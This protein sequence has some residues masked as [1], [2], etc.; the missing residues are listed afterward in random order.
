VAARLL[1]D[2]PGLSRDE[3]LNA[4]GSYHGNEPDAGIR[5]DVVLRL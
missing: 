5:T 1:S 4:V 2:N 3:L